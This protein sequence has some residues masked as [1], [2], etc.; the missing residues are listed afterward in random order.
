M[1]KFI[2]NVGRYMRQSWRLVVPLKRVGILLGGLLFVV[3]AYYIAINNLRT[4]KHVLISLLLLWVVTSYILLPRIHRFLSR[5]YVPDYFIGRARTADGLLADPVN[6]ALRGTEKTLLK[7]MR[8]AGWDLA[9][10][11]TIKTALTTIRA[12]LLKRSYENAPV[13]DLYVFGKKQDLAFQKEVDGNPAKRHH[14]RFWRIP[15]DI[16]LP[17]GHNVDW[18]A[19]A[20]YDDA[21]GLSRFTL[22][23][24]HS[25]DGDVDAERDF[26]VQTIK[27]VHRT[28]QVQKIE[29]FFPKYSHRNGGG[30]AF[31][32]DG[33][34]VVVDLK[35]GLLR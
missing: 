14:V 13:S 15:K 3:A 11:I 4:D 24:T 16:Y 6:L 5:I 32:T 7:T 8:K 21:V 20:T 1:Q 25:I 18:V 29:G 35:K 34:M 17:G 22:Q 23:I 26:V 33:S 31:F 27:R 12:T 2:R 9:D 10:P 28:K 30:D 19:A